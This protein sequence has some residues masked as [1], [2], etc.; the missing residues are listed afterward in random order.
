MRYT[1]SHSSCSDVM[2]A[3]KRR[4]LRVCLDFVT[5]WER[6]Q[7]S[8]KCFL[9]PDPLSLHRGGAEMGCNGDTD[10]GAWSASAMGGTSA[11][12]DYSGPRRQPT[13]DLRGP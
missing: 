6:G 7:D 13:A 9:S 11:L 10:F 5:P 3:E 1:E 12:L 8:T 2:S 4:Y